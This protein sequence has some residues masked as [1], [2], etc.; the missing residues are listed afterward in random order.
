MHIC[1]QSTEVQTCDDHVV[2]SVL[3]LILRVF[4]VRWVGVQTD[5]GSGEPDAVVALILAVLHV[6]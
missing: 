1:S 2:V 6:S 3:R 4:E 5:L